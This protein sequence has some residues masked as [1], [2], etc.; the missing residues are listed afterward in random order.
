MAQRCSTGRG[1]FYTRDSGGKHETTPGEYVRWAQREAAV[2]GVA[3]DCTPKQI[4]SM[5]REGQSR[6]GDLF[7]DYGVAGHKLS[8]AGLDALIHAAL[9]DQAV[10]HIFIPRR[11]RFARPDDAIDAMKLE[12]R[13]REGGLTI[14]FNDR[15][16]EPLTRGR[17]RDMGERV[18]AMF[19]YHNAGDFRRELAQKMLDAQVNLAR[20]GF[21]T[22]G[23]APYGFRRWLARV[24]GTPVRQL[25]DGESVKLAGHHVV[26]LP[27]PDE[28]LEVI[29][30]ILEMLETMPASRVAATLTA[31]GIPTPDAGRQRTDRGVRHSTSGVW[32]QPT[33]VNI[34]RNP[35]L[36]AMMSYGRRSMGDQLRLGLDGPR[37]LEE[38]DLRADGKPKVV[39][40]PE[41]THIVSAASFE[42]MVDQARQRELLQ[43]L[44]QR[45]GTQRGKP[46]S[47]TPAQNPL[48]GRIFDMGCGWPMYRQPYNQGFR[49]LC[50]FY[51]QSHGAECRH[52]HVDGVTATRF[53]LACVRQRVLSPTA[54]EKL[55]QRFRALAEREQK[56]NRP[57][58]MVPV[59][60]VELAEVRRKRELAAKNLALAASPEQY[61][62]IAAVFEEARREEKALEAKLREAEDAAGTAIDPEAE[63]AAAMAMLDGIEELAADP[64]NLE[65]IGV[66]FLRLNA[67][68]F[69]RFEEV[70]Q[71]KRTVNK[72][73]GGL[74][75]FGSSPPPVALYEGPTG[76]RVLIGRPCMP[77]S[78]H[79]IK[80]S[81]SEPIGSDQEGKSLGKVNRGERI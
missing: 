73:S 50:G 35:L 17:R 75:T 48:G 44:D 63:V 52:N 37:N 22:G 56:E 40:N 45:A 3:F 57:D 68:M 49:Y 12:D 27:G 74:V 62:A 39:T 59:R 67:K 77:D 76:R 46:R 32:H 5:I 26:W 9:T 24:G 71:K 11:D 51:Q 60:R 78:S 53:L 72:V 65:A 8:R 81:P 28:E 34:A 69:L 33:V 31:E 18:V 21:S 61:Q 13:L 15:I 41:S 66:L 43:T 42:P 14:V 20:A 1:L 30:R 25:A 10:S 55:S 23:R 36:L 16:L 80:R 70:E 4:E 7:L 6:N 29:R 47:R 54:R 19:D 58:A 2:R 38:S 79:A 64:A